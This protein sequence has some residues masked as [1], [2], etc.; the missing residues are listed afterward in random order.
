MDDINRRLGEFSRWVTDSLN[1]LGRGLEDITRRFG[2]YVAQSIIIWEAAKGAA[3]RRVAE[4]IANLIE[5]PENQAA[6]IGGE[7]AAWL[8]HPALG[9]AVTGSLLGLEAW[10]TLAKELPVGV[11]I[12]SDNPVVNLLFEEEEVR[13]E[14]AAEYTFGELLDRKPAVIYKWPDVAAGKYEPEVE[15]TE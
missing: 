6:L 10:S 5:K 14:G 15:V 9:A 2:T 7:T 13:L 12:E 1:N 8:A 3:R 4:E 11:P